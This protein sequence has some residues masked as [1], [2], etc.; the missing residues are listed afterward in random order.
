MPPNA[1]LP[2]E[3]Y[4]QA[5]AESVHVSTKTINSNIDKGGIRLARAQALDLPYISARTLLADG[6]TIPT[7]YQANTGKTATLFKTLKAAM[8]ADSVQDDAQ[9]RDATDAQTQQII[10]ALQPD[11]AALFSQPYQAGLQHVNIRMR[12]LLLPKADG[13]VSVSPMTAAGVNH[14]FNLAVDAIKDAYKTDDDLHN[15]TTAVF[16]IGGANPQN[17]GSLV[18]AMQRPL[19]LTAPSSDA[20]IRHAFSLY[21]KGLDYYIPNQP[22]I[23]SK[24]QPAL[25]AWAA[26]LNQGLMATRADANGQD[27][28]GKQIE[29]A[30]S[31]LA[32]REAEVKFLG[33]IV[34]GVLAQGERARQVLV[35]AQDRLPNISAYQPNTIDNDTGETV[36]KPV[37]ARTPLLHPRVRLAVQGLI[38][39]NLRDDGW[40]LVFA[41]DLAAHIVRQKY[42]MAG[43][44]APVTLVLDDST[45]PFLAR[46]IRGLLYAFKELA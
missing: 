28:A 4:R 18:R 35:Q 19:Y 36:S 6:M 30:S 21:Y 45:V 14:W 11:I 1:P 16:G 12:Q 32:S 22:S 25:L 40:L 7:D 23:D 17:V 26:M 9:N 41:D 34:R 3:L 38:D 39:P 42:R 24:Y 20:S 8:L 33:D 5:L 10:A 43:Q 15:L 2:T 27:W 44:L 29:A 37:V 31:D 13:Y 46:R